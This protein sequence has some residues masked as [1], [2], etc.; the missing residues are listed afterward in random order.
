MRHS[1]HPGL[2]WLTLVSLL[3]V[4]CGQGPAG[5][6]GPPPLSVAVAEVLQQDVPVY[7]EWIASTDGAVNATI[8]AQ[9]QGYLIAQRYREGDLVEKGQVLFEIDPRTFQAKLDQAE[10][11]EQQAVAA[12]SQA[13]AT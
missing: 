3:G 11:A 4:G 7:L 9:V 10:A 12:L 13:E 8:R 5:P 2:C 1:I 6:T